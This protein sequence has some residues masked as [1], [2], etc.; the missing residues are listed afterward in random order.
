[1]M[2]SLSEIAANWRLD[3]IGYLTERIIETTDAFVQ[4]GY[5]AGELYDDAIQ[6]TRICFLCR[7]DDS[8]RI[9]LVEPFESNRTMRKMTEKTGVSPYHL[10]Y[11]VPDMDMAFDQMMEA[12]YTALSRP[13]S[14]VAFGGRKICYFWKRETGFMELVSKS[15]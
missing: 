13:V 14:A 15:I 8:L 10:C 5:V 6:R 1:M 12:G 9:E 11:E 7:P 2:V 4:L 3:H